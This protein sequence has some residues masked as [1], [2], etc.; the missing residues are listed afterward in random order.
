MLVHL[1][2]NSV[3]IKTENM[4]WYLPITIIP[5]IGL[6]ILSTIT[7]M[8]N[9]STEIS[10]LVSSTCSKFQHTISARKIKQLGLL[11]RATAMLYVATGCY[12]LSGIVGVIYKNDAAWSLP[13]LTLYIGTI[14]IFI[15]IALLI[16]YAFRAVK[17]RKDQ[18]A[19]TT[20]DYVED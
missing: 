14:F 6:L 18:F 19:N 15:A 17:I 20:V 12:V 11:T 9:L 10:G 1:K 7:Q 3:E 4:N 16:V 5:G 8:L 13:S 2:N